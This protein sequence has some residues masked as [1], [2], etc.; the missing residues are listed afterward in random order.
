MSRAPSRASPG[1]VLCSH[2]FR[3]LAARHD[4]GTPRSPQAQLDLRPIL[5]HEELR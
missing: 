4:G 1:R 3:T 2:A 5:D